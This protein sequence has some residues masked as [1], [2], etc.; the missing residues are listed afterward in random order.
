MR[1]TVQQP[2]PNHHFELQGDGARRSRVGG[3]SV[4]VV[5]RL[6]SLRRVASHA[7]LALGGPAFACAPA[8][9]AASSATALAASS[10]SATPAESKRE[11]TWRCGGELV[12]P[13]GWQQETAFADAS[14][15]NS[16][17]Q[18]SSVAA[19]KLVKRL[20]A[21]AGGTGCDYLTA[22]TRLWKTGTNGKDVCAMAVIKSED[23]AEWGAMTSATAALD[24][25]LRS[26]AAEILTGVASTRRVAVDQVVD[27]GVPGGPRAEWLRARMDRFLGQRAALVEVPKGWAGEGVPPGVDVVVRASLVSRVEQGVQTVESTWTARFRDG[28]KVA[29]APVTFAEQA[30]P[31]PPTRA[32]AAL[33]ESKGLSVRLD[34]DRGGSLCPG[35]RSQIWLKSDTAA[36]VRVFDLYGAG[37]ALVTFPSVDQPAARVEAGQT[38]ALGGPSGFEATPVPGSEQERFFVVAAPTEQALGRLAAARGECRVPKDLALQLWTGQGIPPGVKTATTGYRIT[39]GGTCPAA[40]G[41]AGEGVV[42]ALAAIPV[43]AL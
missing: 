30:G 34:S 18:A 10:A 14:G 5:A 15:A 23:L 20:C 9:P 2:A 27:L 39:T 37:E 32:L 21:T 7:A 17:D 8:P 25:K 6:V 13:S 35:E 40:R 24:D 28:H 22:H 41:P 16:R 11:E 1:H 43:C 29:S 33:P 26:A 31:P 36:Y 19:A 4:S 38:V 42:Q 3:D 12:P